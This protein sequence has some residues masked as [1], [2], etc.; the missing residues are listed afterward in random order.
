MCAEVAD[1]NMQKTLID[2]ISRNDESIEIEAHSECIDMLAS[3]DCYEERQMHA[4]GE[5]ELG[6]SAR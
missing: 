3:N 1:E 6:M 4:Q 5:R 2:F